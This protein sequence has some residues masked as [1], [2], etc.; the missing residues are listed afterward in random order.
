[1]SM[2]AAAIIFS[3]LNNNTLSRLTQD[4]T[5]A[6]IPFAC[7]YRLIDFALSNVVNAGISN[8]N[9][10]TNYNY[11]SL[12]EHIGSGKDFDLARRSGG[13]NVISPYQT[14]HTPS[15]KL[16][17]SHLEALRS[18]SHSYI[19]KFKEE[20]VVLSDCDLICNIDLRDVLHEHERN[21]ADITVVTARVDSSWTSKTAKLMVSAGDDAR[22]SSFA[23]SASYSAS[24][25][26]ICTN[27]FVMKT[28]TL[29]EILAAADRS[30]YTSLTQD[31]LIP[32]AAKEKFYA[33][34]YDGYFASVSSFRDYFFHSIELTKNV[35]LRKQL[36]GVAERPIYTNVHNSSPT[37]YKDTASVKNSLIADGCVIEGTVE[38]SV[39][40]RG[41]RVKKGAVVRNSVLFFESSVGENTTLN[42]VIADKNTIINDGVT[43]SGHPTIPFYINK[44]QKV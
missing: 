38:N 24:H 4:R 42:C 37:V 26:E 15:A 9:V 3:N 7:R 36:L 23:M 30:D 16:Y 20:N 25:P 29:R 21:V 11:R 2:N 27:I 43:L 39:I 6:A 10:V 31:I 34:R 35:T 32:N 41:V 22:I 33:Y 8:V 14:S 12:V 18:I 44:G 13:I 40:F 19:D 17:S 5:V 28:N 1:M